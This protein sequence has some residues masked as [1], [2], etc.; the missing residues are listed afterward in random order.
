LSCTLLVSAGLL[1]RSLARLQSIQPGF[2]PQGVVLAH[3]SLPIG[4]YASDESAGLWFDSLLERLSSTPGVE[5]AGLSSAP[6]LTGANDT[7]VHRPERPPASAQDR[8]FAQLRLIDGDYFPALRVPVLAGR[9]SRLQTA[10]T[11]RPS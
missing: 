8:R 2:D 11:P 10:G 1:V 6:P 3:V 7:S 9:D 4:K 5:A